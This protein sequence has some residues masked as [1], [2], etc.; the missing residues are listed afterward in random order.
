[1][2][3]SDEVRSSRLKRPDKSKRLLAVHTFLRFDN[4]GGVGENGEKPPDTLAPT[5]T[6]SVQRL[7][8]VRR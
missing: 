1:M 7:Q 3:Q 2:S 4:D 5:G 8:R 6:L